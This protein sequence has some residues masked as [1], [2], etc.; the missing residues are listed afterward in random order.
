MLTSAENIDQYILESFREQIGEEITVTTLQGRFT[1]K[2][3]SVD[4]YR[5]VGRQ[6]INVGSGIASSEIVFSVS[7][8]TAREKISRMG[9]EDRDS[10]ALVKG[11]MAYDSQ[12]YGH[13]RRFFETLGE[14]LAEG[15]LA[16]V[17]KKV[18]AET[19]QAACDNLRLLLSSVGIDVTVEFDMKSWRNALNDV[20][21]DIKDFSKVTRLIDIYMSEYGETDFVKSAAPVFA[22]LKWL[23]ERN[24]GPQKQSSFEKPLDVKLH[25]SDLDLGWRKNHR[26]KQLLFNNELE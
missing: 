17:D 22:H 18:N 5:I 15:L 12:A 26:N 19:E 2:V 11:I 7:D 25:R 16:E 21:I 6:D 23:L 8:L 10:V 9:S 13:A 20:S 4:N 1:I 14:P 3:I 24:L